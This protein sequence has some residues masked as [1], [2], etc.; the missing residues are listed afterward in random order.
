MDQKDNQSVMLYSY[1][2]I[3]TGVLRQ[4]SKDSALDSNP[5]YIRAE[6]QSLKIA[7]YPKLFELITFTFG[8]G[9]EKETTF[10]AP[11]LSNR[12]KPCLHQEVLM[13]DRAWYS[14]FKKRVLVCVWCSHERLI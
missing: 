13:Y 1:I 2:N 11:D 9:N 3:N 10:R 6:G 4:E 8:M 12:T 5:N 7:D 14:L